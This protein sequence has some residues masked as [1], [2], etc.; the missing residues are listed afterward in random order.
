[1]PIR[2]GTKTILALPSLVQLSLYRT[3]ARPSR[4]FADHPTLVSILGTED[5]GANETRAI[6][7]EAFGWST[8]RSDQ[9]V[10][11]VDRLVVWPEL[12]DA[13]APHSDYMV[14][15]E[16]DSTAA[17]AL[18]EELGVDVT[19]LMFQMGIAFDDDREEALAKARRIRAWYGGVIW[20]RYDDAIID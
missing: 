6:L 7:G 19:K 5:L 10:V 2:D 12:R 11:L 18:I 14:G 17:R 15:I 1:M 3:A 20:D 8:R 13:L 16:D 4:E 9:Y